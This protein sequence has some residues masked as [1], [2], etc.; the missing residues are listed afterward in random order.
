VS[1]RRHSQST[2]VQGYPCR[3]RTGWRKQALGRVETLD[4][5]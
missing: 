4:R 2:S 5:H 3:R 1:T